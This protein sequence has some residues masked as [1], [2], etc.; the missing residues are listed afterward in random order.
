MLFVTGSFHSSVKSF[1]EK[2]SKNSEPLSCSP[3][4]ADMLLVFAGRFTVFSIGFQHSR[5]HICF[6]LT[7]AKRKKIPPHFPMRC[8]MSPP[9]A[10]S[11]PAL[12]ARPDMQETCGQEREK[13]EKGVSAGDG[14]LSR[15][16]YRS[17]T[18][19]TIQLSSAPV[20]FL[21]RPHLPLPKRAQRR[22][23]AVGKALAHSSWQKWRWMA[24]ELLGVEWG[25]SSTTI[26][27]PSPLSTAPSPGSSQC[28][29]SLLAASSPGRSPP[30]SSPSA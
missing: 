14:G 8:F 13:S 12:K 20:F 1:P 28:R 17:R 5:A 29:P 21:A 26:L 23:G 3:I 18:G 24:R 6:D 2:Y 10:S 27:S 11:L 7:I 19:I 16:Q 22:P 15:K 30:A 4:F 25:W 9:T